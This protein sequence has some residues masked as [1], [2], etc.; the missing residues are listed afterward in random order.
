MRRRTDCTLEQ[1][2]NRF[3]ELG[4]EIQKVFSSIE[5][6][7]CV[8]RIRK[9]VLRLLWHFLHLLLSIGFFVLG[10]AHVLQSCIISS[11]LLAKYR[12]LDLSNLQCLAVVVDSEE[13]HHTSRVV[14]IVRW[15]SAIG[16]K[17]VCLYDVDGVLKESKEIILKKL[18]NARLSEEINE[19]DSPLHQKHVILEF[20]SISDG[21]EGV[22]KAANFLCS[23]YLKPASLG[24]NQ[25][26]LVFTEPNLTRAL[27]AVGLFSC[28][29]LIDGCGGPEPNLLLVCGPARCHLGFPAW[30]LRYTE[31]TYRTTKIHEIWFPDKSHSQVHNGAPKLWFMSSSTFG[32]Q[33]LD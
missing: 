25:E 15:L 14:K 33:C 16:V 22:A 31:I 9:L 4:D 10:I 30:R 28:S 2:N 29:D 12:S 23:K 5:P 17:H 6:I 20:V 13:A 7:S 1:S 11:G 19:K 24:G 8:R 21:K 3:I 27:S 18:S 26:E 32:E